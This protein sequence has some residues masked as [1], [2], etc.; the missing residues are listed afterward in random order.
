MAGKGHMTL[1]RQEN[2]EFH[3]ESS[4]ITADLVQLDYEGKSVGLTP[5]N[6][7]KTTV[8]RFFRVHEDGLHK[9]LNVI[10][11]TVLLLAEKNNR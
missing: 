1:K 6:L 3:S 9:K 11:L 10:V 4:A 8:A 7:S 2:W 5:M